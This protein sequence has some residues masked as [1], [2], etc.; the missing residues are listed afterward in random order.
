VTKRKRKV[1]DKLWTLTELA[2]AA[3][4]T[5]DSL[6]Q[7]IHR[8]TLVAQLMGHGAR[9]LWLVDEETAQAVIHE[10]RRWSRRDPQV[11]A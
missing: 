6:R 7:R 2:A 9:G 1:Q 8:G 5:P 3:G 10:G 4:L 11:E